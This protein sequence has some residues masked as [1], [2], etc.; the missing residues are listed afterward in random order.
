[1]TDPL[2]VLRLARGERV[3]WQ[4]RAAVGAAWPS[5]RRL[6]LA[7][8]PLVPALAASWLVGAAPAAVLL[9][10]GAWGYALVVLA[11]ARLLGP[12]YL[13]IMWV[14]L[15]APIASIG[16]ARQLAAVGWQDAILHG[17]TAIFLGA[18]FVGLPLFFLMLEVLDRLATWFVVTDA[19]VAAVRLGGAPGV[20]W[21]QRL[22][23]DESLRVERTWREP[24]GCLVIGWRRLRL[25]DDDPA[26]V[27]ETVRAARE[28]RA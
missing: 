17:A 13:L 28:G 27:L 24:D 10:V 9:L 8:L 15:A 18:T 20:L 7:A 14:L 21:E 2:D 16:W 4:G 26:R 22:R 6:A 1:M 5:Y 11:A 25:R 3:L 19:R 23:P 12:S